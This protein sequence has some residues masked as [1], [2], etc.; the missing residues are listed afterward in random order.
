MGLL[1][2]DVEARGPTRLLQGNGAQNEQGGLRRG[3]HVHYIRQHNGR[4]QLR[5]EV[6]AVMLS[7]GRA[8]M[9]E[10]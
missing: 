3:H 9:V 4:F 5:V 2:Q 8:T 6:N 1:H 7:L 10:D